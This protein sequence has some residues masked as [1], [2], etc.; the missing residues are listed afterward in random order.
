MKYLKLT[1]LYEQLDSTTKRLE[2]TKILSDFLKEIKVE[3]KDILYLLL[4]RIYPEYDERVLGISSQ[5]A[6]KAISKATGVN[7]IEIVKEWKSLGDIGQVAEK[8]SKKKRQATLDKKELSVKK[9]IENLRAIPELVGKGTIDKKLALITELLTSAS[10]LESKYLIR[11]LIGD[12]RIGTQES[13]IRDAIASAFF[14]KEKEKDPK[15]TSDSVQEALD[16]SNDIAEVF[17]IATKQDLKLL[18]KI[19]LEIGKPVKLMLA[20]KAVDIHEGF[21]SLGKPCALEYKYD[22]FRMLIHK[23]GD[24]VFLYTRRLENVTSQFPEIIDYVRKYTKGESL[25]IDSEAVGYNKKTKEY[26]PFQEISQRIKRKYDIEKIQEELP[27]EVNVF[28][29]LYYNGK[30]LIDEPFK[31]RSEIVKEIVEEKPYKIVCAKQI[32]TDSEKKAEEFYKKALADNQEGI[33]M[34]NL[35]APYQSGR[36]VGHM[37]KLKPNQR[38]LDLVITGAEYGTGKRSGWMSSFIVSCQDGD[39]F[40]EIGKVGTGIKEKSEEGLSFEELTKKLTPLIKKEKGR[41]VEIK[42]K[43]VV[44]I[45]YQEIQKSP[46]YNSGFALR[47][48]RVTVLRPDRDTAD[49]ATLQEIQEDYDIQ[50]K[51]KVY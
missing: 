40:L 7:S 31:K 20:Q 42:P 23:K 22:G 10:P 44:S 19:P 50:Q 9:V 47:F 37:L 27:V 45:T 11:T 48:P 15:E 5:L 2:K 14:E 49:I 13:T 30:S 36:R 21:E 32:I 41:T 46:T 43:L 28:D 34:K 1:E 51:K 18:R 29:V 35:D 8:I 33:M 24:K 16:K 12:L 26:R 38:E 3:E 6:V 39:E 25:M 4:G 17:E